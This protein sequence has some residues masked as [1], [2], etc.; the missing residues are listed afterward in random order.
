MTKLPVT[1]SEAVMKAL[2]KAGFEAIRQRG[3]HVYLRHSDGRA[4]V[5]PIHKG[6]DIDRGLLRKILRDAD[7]TREDF[8]KLLKI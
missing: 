3:S 4:T 2:Q 8:L 7:L 1:S 5:I 6:R